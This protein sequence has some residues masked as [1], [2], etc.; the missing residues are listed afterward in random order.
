MAKEMRITIDETT[1]K[2]INAMKAKFLLK[3]IELTKQAA[4]GEIA[5]EWYNVN[6]Q[7]KMSFKQSSANGDIEHFSFK[8]N[9]DDKTKDVYLQA[10]DN[11]ENRK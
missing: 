11:L 9:V 8:C 1:N 10:I 6:T 2:A 4:L 5:K 3:D 7:K